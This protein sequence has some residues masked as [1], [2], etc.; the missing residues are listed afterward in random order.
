MLGTLQEEVP[1]VVEGCTIVSSRFNMTERQMERALKTIMEYPLPHVEYR[2][3]EEGRVQDSQIQEAID[4]WRKFMATIL[5][6]DG[7]VGMISPIVDE[8]WHAHILF[9]KEYA[10]FCR[11]VFGQFIG[12]AP[13]WP[14]APLSNGGGERFIETYNMLFGELP[15]IWHQHLPKDAQPKAGSGCD[16][17]GPGKCGV[18]CR[19]C[20]GGTDD[21]CQTQ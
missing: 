5:Y 16:D 18:S 19:D 6:A 13:N 9:T 14:G 20:N 1:V 15:A 4:E 21:D 7:P 12:H 11:N 2:L 10:I 17:C 8:V 3:H